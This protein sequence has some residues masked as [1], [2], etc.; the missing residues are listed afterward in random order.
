M[1]TVTTINLDSLVNNNDSSDETNSKSQFNLP[2]PLISSNYHNLNLSPSAK[3]SSSTGSSQSHYID[4][5][6][7]SGNYSSSINDSDSSFDGKGFFFNLSLLL[8]FP[9]NLIH[10]HSLTHSL[11]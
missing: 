1:E 10:L 11:T 4:Y 3:S 9:F 2:I 7:D 5:Y 6:D 8:L